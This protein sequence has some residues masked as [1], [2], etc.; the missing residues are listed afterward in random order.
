MLEELFAQPSFEF[1][2]S[3]GKSTSKFYFGTKLVFKTL[4]PKEL[5]LIQ[6]VLPSYFKHLDEN[7]NSLLVKIYGVFET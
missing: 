1:S 3:P 4:K 7:P 6:K 2:K 5:I